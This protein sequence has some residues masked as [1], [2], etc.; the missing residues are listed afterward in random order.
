MTRPAP[1][2]FLICLA[3]TLSMTGTMYFPALLPSFQAEWGLTN[4]AA[5]WIN[6]VFFA[7]YAVTSPILVGLTDRI[8]ARRIYLPSALLAALSLF[9]FGWLAEGTWTAAALRLLAGIGLAGTYMPGLRALSD[10]VTGPRQS[11]YI[12]FYT[13]SYGIGTA[14]SVYLAGLLETVIGW[15][16]GAEFLALGPL[17]ALLIFAALVP[18]RKPPGS[19]AGLRFSMSDLKTVLGN[20]PAVGYMLGYGVHCW[21]LFGYRSW[22]VAFLVF[23]LSLQ[24]GFTSPLSPQNIAMIILLAGV[25]ASIVGNEGAMAWGRRRAITLFMIG[26]GLLGCVIGFAAGLDFYLVAA[27][28][29]L[30]GMTNLFDSGALTAGVV[31]ESPERQRGLTLA[32]Y[33]FTGFGMAFLAPLAFGAILDAAGRGVAAWGLAFAALGLVCLSGALWLRIFRA[34]SPH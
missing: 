21:E 11:R 23:S 4:T 14:L 28:C 9:L 31:S 13:A 29:L 5:G 15:R 17:G 10:N 33:S 16:L 18:P 19:G 24:Q 32:V 25:P 12:V 2:V 8:D 26:S 27:L 30:Y 20:R 22:L 3:E 7:G 34:R 1:F 6:G